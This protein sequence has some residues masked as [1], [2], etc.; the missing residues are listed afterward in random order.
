MT[1]QFKEPQFVSSAGQVKIQ[2]KIINW[3]SHLRWFLAQN[4]TNSVMFRA[5]CSS[6]GD[7]KVCKMK[8]KFTLWLSKK[9]AVCPKHNLLS[10]VWC[11]SVLPTLDQCIF[12]LFFSFLVQHLNF[13]VCVLVFILF[14]YS[15]SHLLA[16]RWRCSPC[17]LTKKR[18]G[19][20]WQT[21]IRILVFVSSWGLCIE[22]H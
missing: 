18:E 14:I 12:F 13:S 20:Q 3:S 21:H 1:N 8:K 6:S 7:Q 22:F 16:L 15:F 11:R 17:F 5:R 19:T 9:E 4:F 10:T 2:G